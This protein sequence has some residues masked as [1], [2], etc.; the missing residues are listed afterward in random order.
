MTPYGPI[1]HYKLND[2][3]RIAGYKI[4]DKQWIQTKDLLEN[5]S[6]A[7]QG[8]ANEKTRWQKRKTALPFRDLNF[9]YALLKTKKT[10]T[11]SGKLKQINDVE[12]AMSFASSKLIDNWGKP[13]YLPSLLAQESARANGEYYNSE[14]RPKLYSSILTEL[15]ES[16]KEK[17]G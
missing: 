6:L 10:I 7:N 8:S 14:A 15:E 9:Q 17:E 1:E 5:W 12:S 16:T 3:M 2:F 4:K 13:I 11:E